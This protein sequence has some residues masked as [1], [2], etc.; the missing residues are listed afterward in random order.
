MRTT[1]LGTDPNFLVSAYFGTAGNQAAVVTSFSS[2]SVTLTNPETGVDTTITGTGFSVNGTG[3]LQGGTITSFSMSNGGIPQGTITEISWDAVAFD[4]A[5]D[6]VEASGNYVPLATLIDQ[7]ASVIIDASGALGSVNVFGVANPWGS[8]SFLVTTP[9]TYLDS[10]FNDRIIT[11]QGNDTT[12]FTP[13]M[14]DFGYNE[15]EAS[16]GSDTIDFSAVSGLSFVWMDYED[17]VDGALTFNVNSVANTG[18]VAGVGFTDTLID[19]NRIMDADGIGLEGGDGNDVYNITNASGRYFNLRGN[20]G[21]DVFNLNLGG[22]ARLTYNF[23]SDA[24]PTTG[25]NADLVAGTITDGLGGTDTLNILSGD[26]VLEIG[27]TYLADTFLGSTRD[28]SFITREGNDTVDGGAGI[29]RVRYDRGGVDVVTVDLAAQTAIATISGTDFTDT[30]INIEYVRGSRNGDDV[31]SGA[32]TDD[33]FGGRGGND[34][35]DGRAGNDYAEGGDGNDSIIGGSGDDRLYGNDGNDT[36][37][38][39][40]GRDKLYGGDGNDVLDASGGGAATQGVGDN[41]RAGLGQDTILGHAGSWAAGEGINLSYAFV[42]GVGGL[43]IVAGANGTGT[44]VSGD[45]RVNDTFTYAHDFA[46]SGDDDI[47]TGSSENRWEGFTGNAGND[48]LDGGGGNGTAVAVYL[49]EHDY[50]GTQG[51][52]GDLQTGIVTDTFGQTDTL[53]NMT[54]V[55]GSVFDDVLDATGRTARI[56]LEGHGGDDTMTGGSANDR[57]E[58]GDGKD[59]LNGGLGND[60]LRGDDGADN[61]RGEAGGDVLSGGDGNDVL[62]GGDDEDLL[63]GG[64]GDDLLFGGSGFDKIYGGAGFDRI[65][66]GAANDIANGG[67]DNDII[68]TGGGN[69]LVFAQSGNDL[70]FSQN[71]N[72]NIFAGDGNDKVFAGLGNDDINLGDG[73][74]EVFAG[75]GVD[76]IIGAGGN[77]TLSGGGDADTFVFAAGQGNDRITDLT[78]ADSIDISAFGVSD[79]GASTQDWRDATTSVITSGG[80]SNVTIAWDGGGTLT[81]EGIGIAALTDANFLF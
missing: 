35:I 38:G 75:G 1:Y 74:D 31:L 65:F 9:I 58:G 32:A 72:D 2:T 45:M 50:G 64:N 20:E 22:Y 43:T 70:V 76:M 23:G 56:E 27:G 5:L 71:G 4:A 47:I 40:D 24:F 61:L 12:V 44:V 59:L 60:V 11:A 78:A 62:N 52:V 81:F 80:G 3:A 17:F 46:G 69:D 28:D 8:L 68:N 7:S 16:A 33:I 39:G 55:Q 29:D 67:A 49:Y 42:S 57:I 18:S 66:G 15:Y 54:R 41:I 34:T 51:I 37:E 79:T 6:A 77:D 48:T 36:L 63:F 14:I 19:V 25:I 73:N 26:G 30:L 10:P 13:E 53:L 21:N